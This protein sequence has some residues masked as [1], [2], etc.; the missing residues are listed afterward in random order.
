MSGSLIN[1]N[2][3]VTEVDLSDEPTGCIATNFAKVGKMVVKFNTNE[4]TAT[5]CDG[6]TVCLCKYSQGCPINTYQ[7]ES[8]CTLAGTGGRGAS[9]KQCVDSS[10]VECVDGQYQNEIGTG[11]NSCKSCEKG[12]LL[13][14][15]VCVVCDGQITATVCITCA[16]GKYGYVENV[17]VTCIDCPAGFF[18]TSAGAEE[19]TNCQEDNEDSKKYTDQA[20]QALCK[21]CPSSD[22]L[23][24][25]KV[26]DK[27][28][29]SAGRSCNYK[30]IGC[31][32][33][34]KS[35]AESVQVMLSGV[36]LV[37]AAIFCTAY[38]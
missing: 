12:S 25:E 6:G 19:C 32:T 37:A 13:K 21:D 9:I 24:Q 15:G 4:E 5:A 2:T 14:D 34:M 30:N 11:S 33:S 35:S 31:A 22:M 10:C 3:I 36:M 8:P 7:T 26:N 18:S 29:S 38:W 1:T 17:D 20:G 27:C 16:S 28:S 23:N